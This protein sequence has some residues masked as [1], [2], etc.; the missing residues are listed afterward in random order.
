M[1]TV[2]IVVTS[3]EFAALAARG[4]PEDVA[5]AIVRR[6][7]G[8]QPTGLRV[9]IELPVV[10]RVALADLEAAGVDF[11]PAVAARAAARHEAEQGPWAPAGPPLAPAE[12]PIVPADDPRHRV[13]AAAWLAARLDLTLDPRALAGMARRVTA[14]LGVDASVRTTPPLRELGRVLVS[15]LGVEVCW[16]PLSPAVV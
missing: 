9:E 7:V 14:S 3:E 15:A 4:E 1:M 6:W 11:D 2:E 16:P 8:E 13:M 5:A 12:W 10:E